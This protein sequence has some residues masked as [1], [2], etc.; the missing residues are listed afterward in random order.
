MSMKLFSNGKLKNYYILGE[1]R[2]ELTIRL[3]DVQ[4]M[5]TIL[6]KSASVS[7]SGSL[8]ILKKRVRIITLSNFVHML[9][10]L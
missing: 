7:E 10:F 5:N 9:K 6:I 2:N 1:H 4:S 3:M 8:R